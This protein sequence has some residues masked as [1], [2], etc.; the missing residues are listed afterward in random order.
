MT[1]QGAK[2]V[3]QRKVQLLV[4]LGLFAGLTG[5]ILAVSAN[6]S[7]MA[8]VDREGSLDPERSGD[9]KGPASRPGHVRR[10]ISRPGEV[11]KLQVWRNGKMHAVE[12]PVKREIVL[13]G[14]GNVVREEA[15]PGPL[16]ALPA[17]VPGGRAPTSAEVDAAYKAV[18]RDRPNP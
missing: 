7:S 17:E 16:P 1:M 3:V 2:R 8:G 5:A 9:Q 15:S 4:L 14:E 11:Q 6:A 13:D 12:V 18:G 10:D